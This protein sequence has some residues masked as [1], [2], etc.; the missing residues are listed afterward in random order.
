MVSAKVSGITECHMSLDRLL[1]LVWRGSCKSLRLAKVFIDSSEVLDDDHNPN[2]TWKEFAC[3]WAQVVLCLAAIWLFF[4]FLKHVFMAFVCFVMYI[5]YYW[6]GCGDVDPPCTSP[7]GPNNRT[8]AV[9][10]FRCRALFRQ[11]G[12]QD[13]AAHRFSRSPSG[14]PCTTARTPRISCLI[15]WWRARLLAEIRDVRRLTDLRLP[16][17]GP[18]S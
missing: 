14:K 18:G 7:D 1:P 8:P 17:V 2:E 13:G 3:R 11:L 12:V 10:R 6:A 9:S 4:L 16:Q 15:F 5:Y